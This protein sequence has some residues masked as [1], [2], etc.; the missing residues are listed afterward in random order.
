MF[1][2]LA[3]HTSSRAL[4]FTWMHG[5]SRS[6][7]EDAI[8]IDC[9]VNSDTVK[10]AAAVLQ[11]PRLRHSLWIKWPLSRGVTPAAAAHVQARHFSERRYGTDED[12]VIL[13]S[14]QES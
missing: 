7:K 3:V 12:N 8:F 9:R 13:Q 4:A 11:P 1:G 5:F 10:D 6:K 2:E 14:C